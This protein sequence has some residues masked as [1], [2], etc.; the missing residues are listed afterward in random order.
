MEKYLI[1]NLQLADRPRERLLQQGAAALSDVELISILLGTGTK[2][3]PVVFLAQ[4]ILAQGRTLA[5]AAASLTQSK[6][7]KISGMGPAKTSVLLAALE[8]GKR[9]AMAKSQSVKYIANAKDAAAYL[10]PRLRYEKTEQFVV[11][12]LNAKHHVTGMEK[13][14]EGSLNATIVHPREVFGVAVEHRAAAIIVGHNHPSGDPKPS[15]EDRTLTK[16]LK[17]AGKI[18]GIPLLDHVIIGDGRYYSFSDFGL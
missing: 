7:L 16:T 4:K 1:K 5:E 2:E 9:L 14:S 15:S 11:I 18:I 17:E 8:L 3:Y 10:M 13:I 12:F 6:L